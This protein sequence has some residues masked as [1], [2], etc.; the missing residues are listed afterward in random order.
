[1]QTR[2]G[3]NFWVVKFTCP[4]A[5]KPT[6]L[7]GATIGDWHNQLADYIEKDVGIGGTVSVLIEQNGKYTNI[8]KVDMKSAVKG[9]VPKSPANVPQANLMSQKD[10]MIISQ[11]LT[12]AWAKSK[13]EDPQ[14]I[15][16]AYRFFVSE[17]EQ[18]G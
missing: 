10:I 12:K 2:T 14:V 7:N 13:Y 11:C 18:K 16:D 15:L 17:L 4:E 5:D 3:K 9:D 8:T 1:M 6:N